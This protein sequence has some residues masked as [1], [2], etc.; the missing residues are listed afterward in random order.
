MVNDVLSSGS[1]LLA[2]WHHGSIYSPVWFC[3]YVSIGWLT[4]RA[5]TEQ[6]RCCTTDY[7]LDISMVSAKKASDT[8]GRQSFLTLY[9]SV[10]VICL[11]VIRKPL[12]T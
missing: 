5:M 12:R 11:C 1:L 9:T 10:K 4:D 8:C 3:L 7:S 6:H 2:V